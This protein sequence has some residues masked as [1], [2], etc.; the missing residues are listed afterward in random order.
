M[1][2]SEFRAWV[3]SGKEFFQG[4]SWPMRS[5]GARD[6]MDLQQGSLK[7]YTQCSGALSGASW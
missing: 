7:Y 4:S 6:D 2:G 1:Q 5:Y 3:S